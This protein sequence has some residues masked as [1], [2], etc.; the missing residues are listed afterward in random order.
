MWKKKMELCCSEVKVMYGTGFLGF[1]H[2]SLASFQVGKAHLKLCE[3]YLFFYNYLQT[4]TKLLLA[5]LSAQIRRQRC[6]RLTSQ[7]P[8]K[9]CK[10]ETK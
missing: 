7:K 5:L 6:L 2:I 1:E 10:S 9:G 4:V 3:R 8:S